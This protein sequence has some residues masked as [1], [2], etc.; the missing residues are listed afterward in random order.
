MRDAETARL[1]VPCF[2]EL[3]GVSTA[4]L[5]WTFRPRTSQTP[6]NFITGLRLER[7]ALLLA[8]TT[9]EIAGIAEECGFE[10][11]SYVY[12]LFGQRYG[13]PPRA[14]RLR[15]QRSISP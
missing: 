15:A 1:G 5:S 9:Q 3:S 11:L 6:T 4:H 8:T 10:T 14:Y 13:L 7:A 2:V 12:R